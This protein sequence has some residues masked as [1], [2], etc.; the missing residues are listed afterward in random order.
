MT[1]LFWIKKLRGLGIGTNCRRTYKR[2]SQFCSASTPRR[3][4]FTVWLRAASLAA[5]VLGQ[6]CCK[7]QFLGPPFVAASCRRTVGHGQNWQGSL[8]IIR[9]TCVFTAPPYLA[10]APALKKDAAK[11]SNGWIKISACVWRNEFDTSAPPYS[12]PTTTILPTP[13]PQFNYPP[14]APTATENKWK[15]PLQS[16]FTI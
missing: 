14:F 11:Q 15:T 10:R 3:D 12:L 7:P 1:K 9:R 6:C 16:L 8:E 2:Q 5:L 4:R 13:H